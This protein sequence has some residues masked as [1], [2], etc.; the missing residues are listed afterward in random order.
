[1]PESPEELAAVEQLL[2]ESDAL[3]G[4]LTRLDQASGTAPD[5]VRDRVRRDY[6]KRLDEI[7]AGLRA[8]A[9]VIEA[10]LDTD[11]RE[12]EQLQSRATASRDALA[13]VELRHAVGEYDGARFENERT[14]HRSDI[15]SF[16]LSLAAVAER[17]SRLE[18][19]HALVV[20]APRP[21]DNDALPA[22]AEEP[23]AVPEMHVIG[24]VDRELIAI[25]DLAPDADPDEVLAIFDEP[26]AEIRKTVAPDS[27]PLSFR[28]VGFPGESR[29]PPAPP[30]HPR[31]FE[32]TPPLGIPAADQPPRFVRPGDRMRPVSPPATPLPPVVETPPPQAAE[33]FSEEIVAAGPAPDPVTAPVGRT[34][35]CGECGAMNRP[36]EWYCEKCGAELTAA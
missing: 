21:P 12:H 3:R 15:E 20:R 1:M 25:A 4:W 22:I 2:A 34:L 10:K 26:Q 8:H 32:S 13:E 6:Q 19:V 17:I 14:R 35:R 7:T 27:G 11:R 5:N 29:T 18:D 30:T 16:D 36:L 33:L 28:P 9:D 24:E 31:A 23:V